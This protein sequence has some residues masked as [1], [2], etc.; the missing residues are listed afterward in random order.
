ME[1]KKFRAEKFL[2]TL[3]FKPGGPKI[4]GNCSP[5]QCDQFC[6]KI[7]EIGAILAIFRPF[8]IFSKIFSLPWAVN[9]MNKNMKQLNL[10]SNGTESA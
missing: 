7:V 1:V 9:H 3:F 10:N 6:P 8:E 4:F 2:K 5:C